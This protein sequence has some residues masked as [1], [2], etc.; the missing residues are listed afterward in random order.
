M[1]N[2]ECIFCKIIRK[3]IPSKIVF[4]NEDVIAFLDINPRSKG[5][6]LVVP[7][8]HFVN[9]DD[10]FDLASKTFDVALIIAE[11]IKKS[12]EPITVFISM[13]PGQVPHFHVRVYPVFKDQIPLIENKP[14]KITEDELNS[15]AQRIKSVE[16]SWE[17][18]KET[19]VEEVTET[20]EE[21]TEEEEVEERSEEDTFWIRR[22]L[23]V[24]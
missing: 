23:E 11:K 1:P 18:R 24:G 22:E 17:G 13:L 19:V 4:E 6:C 15:L 7:K 9:F 8:Q 20:E 12:L 10:N 3:E 2:G 5:M 21:E 16:I 14:L